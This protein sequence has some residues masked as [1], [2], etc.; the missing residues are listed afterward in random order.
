[1]LILL[2]LQKIGSL[3]LIDMFKQ[4]K[5]IIASVSLAIIVSCSSVRK[6]KSHTETKIDSTVIKTVDNSVVENSVKDVTKSAN[7]K[8]EREGVVIDYVPQFDKFGNLIPFFFNKKDKSGRETAV[9]IQGNATVKYYSEEEIDTRLENIKEYYDRKLDSITKTK[10]DIDSTT[11]TDTFNK[12]KAP[13]YLKFIIGLTVVILL[14]IIGI[15][16]LYFYFKKKILNL[17][18]IL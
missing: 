6:T 11:S 5:F 10:T 3:N 7:I 17:T 1:M 14:L 2:L 4:I 12:E 9:S 8:A 18:N 16:I 15:I 13:D